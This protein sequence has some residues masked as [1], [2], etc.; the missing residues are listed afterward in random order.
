MHL[1]ADLVVARTRASALHKPPAALGLARDLL[2]GDKFTGCY[3][4]GGGRR[5]E[6]L[7]YI[8]MNLVPLQ[9]CSLE[10]REPAALQY[11]IPGLRRS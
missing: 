11:V 3:C 10:Q 6:K 2:A 5:R 7:N 8:M 1:I 4:E 9:E